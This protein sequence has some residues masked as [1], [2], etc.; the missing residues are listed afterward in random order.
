M[1]RNWL[2]SLW[3]YSKANPG[4]YVFGFLIPAAVA[5]IAQGQDGDIAGVILFAILCPTF[6]VRYVRRRKQGKR[7]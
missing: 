3:R 6:A 1:I 7:F 5:K 2:K 4:F